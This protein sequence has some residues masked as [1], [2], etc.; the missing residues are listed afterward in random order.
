MGIQEEFFKL[1]MNLQ[2]TSLHR[3]LQWAAG[4]MK[5]LFPCYYNVSNLNKS[6]NI[7]VND[8]FQDSFSFIF[9]Y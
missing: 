1:F 8:F 5:V 4:I 6:I 9:F 7:K 3:A 2:G